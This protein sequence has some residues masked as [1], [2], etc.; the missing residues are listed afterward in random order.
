MWQKT[1]KPA[2]CRYEGQIHPMRKIHLFLA[3]SV[4]LLHTP[5][6]FSQTSPS[7][8]L[9]LKISKEFAEGRND[10]TAIG[11]HSLYNFTKRSSIEA[12]VSYKVN[13]VK[14]LVFQNLGA[15]TRPFYE[16]F[17]QSE[18]TILIPVAYRFNAGFLNFA[19]GTGFHFLLN[20]KDFAGVDLPEKTDWKNSNLQ[21][22]AS[23]AVS[24]SFRINKT[25]YA[26]PEIKYSRYSQ[27]GGSGL[28]LNLSMR[29]R[30]L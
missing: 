7:F 17:N 30:F 5:K 21:I 19:A 10:G 2:T 12:G 14:Y 8:E 20:K 23:L 25:L 9:G 27:N 15:S 22:L 6:S 11:I 4:W 16:P 13:P 3:I 29:R 26:E 1:I 28:Q 18:K 24:K